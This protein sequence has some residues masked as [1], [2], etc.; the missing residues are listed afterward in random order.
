MPR[1]NT[2]FI[3]TSVGFCLGTIILKG[4]KHNKLLSN[5]IAHEFE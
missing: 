3:Y 1:E 4:E 2:P 5:S